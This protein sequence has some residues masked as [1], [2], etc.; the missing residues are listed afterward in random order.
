MANCSGASY[1]LITI[2][3]VLYN[4]PPRSYPSSWVDYSFF[5][6]R[7]KN[8]EASIDQRETDGILPFLLFLSLYLRKPRTTKT[9]TNNKRSNFHRAGKH[10]GGSHGRAYMRSF[11][12]TLKIYKI[13][14]RNG[15][16]IFVVGRF[17]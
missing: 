16:I 7:T 14:R 1:I 6:W 3:L 11:P 17:F 15:L 8:R 4:I 9:K 12:I 5:D 10:R 13:H 2:P